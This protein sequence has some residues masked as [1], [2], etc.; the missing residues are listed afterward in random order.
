[1][2][3]VADERRIITGGK[4]RLHAPAHLSGRKT[5]RRP[6]ARPAATPGR[7]TTASLSG[8]AHPLAIN[9]EASADDADAEGS[10][11]RLWRPAPLGR[12]EQPE[13]HIS[14]PSHPR[15]VP[16][17]P[18]APAHQAVPTAAVS[19]PRRRPPCG[20]SGTACCCLHPGPRRTSGP[21]G[22]AVERHA[23][24]ATRPPPGTRLLQGLLDLALHLVEP[25]PGPQGTVPRTART[26]TANDRGPSGRPAR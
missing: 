12:E 9:A 3:R 20:R 16:A 7:F 23:E 6:P 5:A 13:P 22:E 8:A 15:R 14:S 2:S 17:V 25:R 19:P 24:V 11:R 21:L 10:E 26:T 1:M 18:G 4:C